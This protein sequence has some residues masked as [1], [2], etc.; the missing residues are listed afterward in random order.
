MYLVNKEILQ[1]L[2]IKSAVFNQER[3]VMAHIQYLDFTGVSNLAIKHEFWRWS[4]FHSVHAYE[5]GRSLFYTEL[6]TFVD[7]ILLQICTIPYSYYRI[8]IFW[9]GH[10]IWCNLPLNFYSTK[11]N[12]NEEEE[13]A[14]CLL[15]SLK[16][17][18]LIIWIFSRI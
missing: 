17:W 13:S 7:S 8:H 2:A 11:E 6:I 3:V 10:K 5:F 18:T 1:F 4:T 16:N 9:E 15:L 14:K 12:Q